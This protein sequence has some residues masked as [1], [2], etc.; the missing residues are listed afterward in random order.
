VAAVERFREQL[1][2]KERLAPATVNKYPVML[3]GILKRA[4][5]RHGLAVNVIASVERQPIRRMRRS[6]A[7]RRTPACAS[8]SCSRCGGATPTRGE[9]AR[10]ARSLP[11]YR[12]PGVT[13]S[14]VDFQPVPLFE[15][16][17]E[18]AQ[19]DEALRAARAG[20]GALVVI[21]GPGG[22]GKT[23]LLLSTRG[24]GVETGMTVASAR[25]SELERSWRSELC[26]SCSSRSWW[27]PTGRRALSFS[28]VPVAQRR[29]Q[30]AVTQAA[31]RESVPVNVR[32]VEF[33]TREAA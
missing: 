5:R 2:Y 12:E 31:I 1:V 10:A 23:E 27:G 18:I 20:A 3:H 24:R 15:R 16:D 9:R 25:G 6:S 28:G 21:E 22:I 8:V 14:A 33:S 26:G 30:K 13:D 17:G 32:S 11:G 4:K 19:I 29:P 7:W